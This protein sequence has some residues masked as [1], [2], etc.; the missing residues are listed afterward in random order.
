LNC[1]W[2]GGS[3][4]SLSLATWHLSGISTDVIPDTMVWVPVTYSRNGLRGRPGNFDVKHRNLAQY[5]DRF[6]D[7]RPK[8]YPWFGY[9]IYSVTITSRLALGPTRLFLQFIYRR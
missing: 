7:W 6:R 3:Q 9:T 8:F 5:S 2:G 1:P 4:L